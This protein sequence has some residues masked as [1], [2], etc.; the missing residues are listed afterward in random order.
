MK[1]K[2]ACQGDEKD[3]GVTQTDGYSME[4]SYRIPKCA[5]FLISCCTV[6]GWTFCVCTNAVQ[7]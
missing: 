5:D 7:K 1:T 2:Q 3:E 4:R 6:P